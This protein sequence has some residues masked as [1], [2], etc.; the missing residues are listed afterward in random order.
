MS[1]EL[2][3]NPTLTKLSRRAELLFSIRQFFVERNVIEVETPLLCRTTAT[4]P[5]IKSIKA[6][7]NNEELYLQTS[8]EFAM[9]KLLAQGSG[10]IYQICK[11]F[12]DEPHAR[13]HN[14]EFTMLEWYRPG[15]NHHQLMDEIDALLNRVLNSEPV[16]RFSYRDVFQ[17]FT[18]IDPHNTNADE[19]EK[20]AASRNID[21]VGITTTDDWLDLLFN[22]LIQPHLI[23][24]TF[25]VDYPVSQ[26]QLATIRDDNPPVAERFEL[27]IG[28]VELAN[29]YHELT[30]S[31]E[32]R[33]RFIDDNEQRKSL[34]LDQIRIDEA[35]LSALDSQFPFCAGVALGIDRLLMLISQSTHI[36][37]VINFT[38]ES[39]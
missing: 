36:S 4:S 5:H 3:T 20:F 6:V 7:S 28:G 39:L 18:D 8:P 19:L 38:A 14:P 15:F 23:K 13:Y 1:L 25:I 10:A 37:E 2:K 34:G 12:R 17:Q 24:P 32:Q 27:F 11:A 9:K 29:G 33:Q 30:N 21:V 31:K 16:K 26:A 35:L 22:H